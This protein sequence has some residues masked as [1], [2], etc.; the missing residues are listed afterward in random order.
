M[1]NT[2]VAWSSPEENGSRRLS[3]HWVSTLP[4][5]LVRAE[6]MEIVRVGLYTCWKGWVLHSDGF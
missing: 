5:V 6:T 2:G 4:S 3:S 1:I